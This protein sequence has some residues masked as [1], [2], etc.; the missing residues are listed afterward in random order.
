MPTGYTSEI[1]TKDNLT[2]K[3]FTLKCARAF[4]ACIHQRD[5]SSNTLPKKQEVDKYHLD[6][7]NSAIKKLKNFKKTSKKVLRQKMERDFLKRNKELLISIEKTHALQNK[8]KLMLKK[9]NNW[10]PP[11]TEHDGLKK[12]MIEQIAESI[13]WDCSTSYQ[14]EGLSREKESFEEH[15]VAEL[16]SLEDDIKYHEKKYNEDVERTNKAN[17]WIEELYNSLN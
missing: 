14:E 13:K 5:D 17:R 15:Y 2:F 8:Y 16:K 9:V 1:G 11:S 3:E 7:L 6:E 10:I 4:G 12:F